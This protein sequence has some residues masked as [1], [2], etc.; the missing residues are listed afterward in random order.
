MIQTW[1]YKNTIFILSNSPKSLGGKFG[2]PPKSPESKAL[3][4][5]MEN[6]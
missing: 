3:K 5:N 4:I 2:A 6:R 1:I